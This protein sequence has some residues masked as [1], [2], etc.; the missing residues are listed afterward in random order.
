MARKKPFHTLT[1]EQ[2]AHLDL[3]F[4]RMRD[5]AITFNMELWINQSEYQMEK[6]LEENNNRLPQYCGTTACLA[7]HLVLAAGASPKKGNWASFGP[8]DRSYPRH[9][10]ERNIYGT[11]EEVANQLLGL[12]ADFDEDGAEHPLF[13]VCNWPTFFKN[14]YEKIEGELEGLRWRKIEDRPQIKKLRTEMVELAIKR[15]E[16]WLATGE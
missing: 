5:E 7:G 4:Q 2:R 10:K 14:R 16:K 1:P 11:I 12:P 3:T 8:K 13:Y 15:V 9:L 6:E